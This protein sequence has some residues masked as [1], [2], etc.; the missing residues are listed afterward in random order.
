[1]NTVHDHSLSNVVCIMPCNKPK[2]HLVVYHEIS[3]HPVPLQFPTTRINQKL[4]YYQ[5]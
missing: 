3:I 5:I 2:T 1:M 4:M